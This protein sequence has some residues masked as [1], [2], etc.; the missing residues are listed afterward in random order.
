MCISVYK[1]KSLISL[2]RND[3]YGEKWTER[4]TINMRKEM[5]KMAF[6]SALGSVR[7]LGSDLWSVSDQVRSLKE[8]SKNYVQHCTEA[9]ARHYLTAVFRK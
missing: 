5:Y 1:R 9:V 8:K 4:L 6:L 7:V 2:I 3:L